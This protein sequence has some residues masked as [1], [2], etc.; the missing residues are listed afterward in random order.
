M[1]QIPHIRRHT[2]HFYEIVLLR[3]QTTVPTAVALVPTKNGSPASA[4]FG[5]DGWL[6]PDRGANGDWP[7]PLPHHRHRAREGPSRHLGAVE[8]CP[9][10]S[11]PLRVTP[12]RR[13]LQCLQ[14]CCRC[15]WY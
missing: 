2:L 9:R 7:P 4:H 10:C 12:S 5:K 15:D 11:L 8:V 1:P 14:A 6:A 13:L 3:W